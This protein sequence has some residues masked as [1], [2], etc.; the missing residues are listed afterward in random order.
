[1]F[2]EN[3]IHVGGS[4]AINEGSPGLWYPPQSYYLECTYGGVGMVLL[5]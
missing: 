3:W 1:M 2:M 4:L 5:Y